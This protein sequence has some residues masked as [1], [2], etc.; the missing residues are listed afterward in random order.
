MFQASL[1]SIMEQAN[2]SKRRPNFSNEE[3]IALATAVKER[4]GILLCKFDNNV[5]AKT[6]AVQ[7]QEVT[8]SVNV[9]SL[10][11]RCVPEVRKKFYDLRT[12]LKKKVAADDKYSG[13]TGKCIYTLIM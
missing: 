1:D 7:W 10:V 3:V 13:K 2:S 12:N 4:Q 11:K 5:T 8:D 9:V 6:K